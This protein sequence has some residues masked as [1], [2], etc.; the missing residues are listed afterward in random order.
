M[1]DPLT[2]TVKPVAHRRL[3]KPLSEEIQNIYRT[4]V[5]TLLVLGISTMSCYLYVNSLK[6]AKGYE[7]K[8]LQNEYESL[9]AELR[10]LNQ[11]VIEAQSFVEIGKNEAIERMDDINDHPTSYVDDSNLAQH[12][13]AH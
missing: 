7:L 5:T 11:K 12:S 6:P 9:Q 1:M 10:K 3:R 13:S 4:L 2:R 8:E